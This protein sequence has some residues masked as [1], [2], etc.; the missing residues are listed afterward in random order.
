M[1]FIIELFININKRVSKRKE[2][3]DFFAYFRFSLL[4][5]YENNILVVIVSSSK[6]L[7]NYSVFHK[8]RDLSVYFSVFR[9]NTKKIM[10]L[11]SQFR[12]KSVFFFQIGHVHR[13]K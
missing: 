13:Y 10:V 11:C 9:G 8:R 4:G 2:K 12:K 7:Q 6:E 3:M 1:Y 5:I